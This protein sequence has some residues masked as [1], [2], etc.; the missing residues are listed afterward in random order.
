MELNEIPPITILVGRNNTGKSAFLESVALVSTANLSWYDSLGDDLIKPIIMKRGGF[1][2]ANLMIK[3]GEKKAS[4]ST[5][6]EIDTTVNLSK[7]VI[8]NEKNI[9][10]V[11]DMHSQILSEIKLY[12]KQVQREFDNRIRRTLGSKRSHTDVDVDKLTTEVLSSLNLFISHLPQK[13]KGHFAG[14]I[15]QDWHLEL[16]REFSKFSESRHMYPIPDFE[17]VRSAYIKPSNTLFLMNPTNQYL[18]ELQ[19]RLAEGGDLLRVIKNI[20]KKIKYFD[21]I[22]QLDRDFLVFINGVEKPMPLASMGDGF[23][24]QLAIISA[25]STIKKGIALMEEPETRMHPGYLDS[26]VQEIISSVKT[27]NLQFFIS[28]HSMDFIESVLEKDADLVKIIR[29]YRDEDTAQTDYQILTGSEALE[30]MQDLK[31]DLRGI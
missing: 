2:Y 16:N 23:R 14:I 7:E 24:A 4:I 19:K 27:R 15:G 22:R 11:G 28:T 9:D 3:I 20:R 8:P 26:I 17:I 12:A 25:L 30:D 6:G 31:L 21:D 18:I 10:L 29:M 1:N 5:R 13:G